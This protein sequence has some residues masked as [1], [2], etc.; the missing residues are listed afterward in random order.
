M[1]I[2]TPALVLALRKYS[3]KAM[4]L[5]VFTLSHGRQEMMLYGVGSKKAGR[6][7]YTAMREIEITYDE[8]AGRTIHTLK[9][10]SATGEGLSIES[11]NDIRKNSIAQFM[12]EVLYRAIRLPMTDEVLYEYLKNTLRNLNEAE[13][14]EEIPQR[15][16]EGLNKTMGYDLYGEIQSQ[17]KSPAILAAIL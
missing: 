2:T 9:E 7:I 1:H 8:Q 14:V 11:L 4:L 13:E 15:F 17:L 3:D 16:I 10:A 6:G 5:S 12:A